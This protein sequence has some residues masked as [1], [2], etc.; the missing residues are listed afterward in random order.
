MDV[1]YGGH[2]GTDSLSSL[3]PAAVSSGFNSA[4]GMPAIFAISY[5]IAL[6]ETISLESDFQWLDF[7]RAKAAASSAEG[8]TALLSLANR[9][10]SQG[11]SWTRN[12]ASGF[13]ADWK[14][15]EH[16]ILRA[17][18]Q[19][20]E[21]P[22]HSSAF[23][24]TIPDV[25]QHV[26]TLGVGWKGKMSSVELAYAMDFYYDRHIANDQQPGF[27]GAYGFDGHLLSVAYKFSF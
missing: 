15:A 16:W 25:N 14:F 24:P 17:G 11:Q 12:I 10:G 6:T 4:V 7:S 1:D 18:Y 2:F 23:S 5:G 8:N 21:N 22:V 20:F 9:S 19:F 13:T 26:F 27:D 3:E